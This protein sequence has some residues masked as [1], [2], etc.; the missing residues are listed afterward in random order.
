MLMVDQA[1]PAVEEII[2]LLE[3][4]VSPAKAIPEEAA[5]LA[6]AAAEADSIL[7]EQTAGRWV[8]FSLIRE[9]AA[10]EDLV[11]EAQFLA[12]M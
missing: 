12:Q 5:A 1:H 11:I 9:E 6:T 4:R 7:Q 10:L 8:E 3:V 2:I